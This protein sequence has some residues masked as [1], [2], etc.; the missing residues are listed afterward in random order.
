MQNKLIDYI[1]RMEASA[2]FA[3]KW[4][5]LTESLHD[6]G[7]NVVNY[8]IFP[9]PGSHE[10]P[11]FIEN[12]KNNWVEHYTAQ[13]YGPEDALIP[14]VLKSDVP[15]LMMSVDERQPLRWTTKGMRLISEAKEAGMERAIGF[16]H[17]NSNGLIDGGI[18]I[19]TNL[20]SA[21]DF[22][23]FIE[24]HVS[25][26]YSIYSIT[27]QN[28]HPECRQRI[29]AR[30]LK[31]SPRQYDLLMA[32]WDGLSNKQIAARLKVSEV[33]VSFHLREL[34]RKIGCRQNREIIPRAHYFGLL[35]SQPTFSR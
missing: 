6:L 9:Q 4:N 17:K 28:L 23:I 10:N 21:R 31:I 11:E 34:R 14:H 16:S 1:S 19:G 12:F 35:G 2:T 27:Y 15:A 5:C 24:N 33:T 30:N 8:T 20:M 7:F 25:L 13:D 3:E 26:L 32:L 22:R 29:A 18:A